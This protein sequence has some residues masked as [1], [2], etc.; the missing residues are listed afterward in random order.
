MAYYGYQPT[1]PGWGAAATWAKRQKKKRQAANKSKPLSEWESFLKE[2]TETVKA[3]REAILRQQAAYEAELRKR[4]QFEAEKGRALGEYL[5]KMNIPGV[6]QGVYGN[7]AK[8]IAGFAQGFSGNIR[9]QADAQAQEQ[10]NMLK[11]TGQEGAVRNEGEGMAN[12][13]Y[14][15]GGAIPGTN[16]TEQ[17]AGF[18]AEAALA[19]QFAARIGQLEGSRLY[20]E[21]LSGLDQ[22]TQA[23]AEL[24][25]NSASELMRRH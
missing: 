24:E 2:Y 1:N 13:A 21:G 19:P 20:Q 4:A 17:A 22:F 12:V 25:G 9:T 10:I 6:I 16:L 5:T 3:Q 15:V 14:G 8:D 18:A 23:L 11:G 7:A